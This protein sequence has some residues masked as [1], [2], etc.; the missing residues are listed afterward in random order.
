MLAQGTDWINRAIHSLMRNN[1]KHLHQ[2]LALRF[3]EKTAYFLKT[4]CNFQVRLCNQP[5]DRPCSISSV[6]RISFQTVTLAFLKCFV[7]I[8]SWKEDM[9]DAHKYNFVCAGLRRFTIVGSDTKI[10]LKVFL[11]YASPLPLSW[12][13]SFQLLAIPKMWNVHSS[14]AVHYTVVWAPDAVYAIGSCAWCIKQYHSNESVN[15]LLKMNLRESHQ[16]SMSRKHL[17]WRRTVVVIFT[18]PGCW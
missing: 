6:P 12:L 1:V 11:F 5:C 8:V 18:C 16:V 17:K 13:F 4:F 10:T 9:S 7:Q 14:F 3:C 15:F 2:H